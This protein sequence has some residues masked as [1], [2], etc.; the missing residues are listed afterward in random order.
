M[1][2]SLLYLKAGA[3]LYASMVY[4]YWNDVIFS[5]SQNQSL[6]SLN[7][8]SSSVKFYHDDNHND[9]DDDLGS[10]ENGCGEFQTPFDVALM[11]LT[12]IGFKSI[13]EYLNSLTDLELQRTTAT[14][15]TADDSV[16]A[17]TWQYGAEPIHRLLTSLSA[18]Q[19]LEGSDSD[20]DTIHSNHINH[21]DHTHYTKQLSESTGD[22]NNKDKHGTTSGRHGHQQGKYATKT[23]TDRAGLAGER[24]TL[25]HPFM[26]VGGGSGT[27]Y[28][29]YCNGVCIYMYISLHTYLKKYSD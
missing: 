3:E 2:L 12:N 5:T 9:D 26:N 15:Y 7:S 23:E 24:E 4:L 21:T 14:Q 6:V 8:L 17:P 20:S 29:L 19:A 1:D 10:E 22:M 11:E 28:Q 13:S 25:S 18:L 27:G 16:L